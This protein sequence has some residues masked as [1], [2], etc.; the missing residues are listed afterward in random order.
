[1]QP[2]WRKASLISSQVEVLAVV[3]RRL[4][5]LDTCSRAVAF[6]HRSVCLQSSLDF[7]HNTRHN[8]DFRSE[9]AGC[10]L[11]AAVSD[12]WDCIELDR[13]PMVFVQPNLRIVRR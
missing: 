7:V 1:M 11:V 3:D 6:R 4:L 10:S 5:L 12:S 2:L 8:F 13:G 9:V